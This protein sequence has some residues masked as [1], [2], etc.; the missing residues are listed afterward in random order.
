MAERN[1]PIKFFQ[2]RQKDELDTEGRGGDKKLP[3]WASADTIKEKAEY[4]KSVFVDIASSLAIKVKNNNYV[5]SVV[6]VKM[7]EDALAKTY[8]KEVAALFNT[9]KLN[10]IGVNGE[11]E[12]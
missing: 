5:P 11:D 10:L 8:R 9:G 3:K 12:D 7:N 6:K 2:K 4:A 1:L